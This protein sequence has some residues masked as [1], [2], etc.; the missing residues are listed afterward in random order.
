MEDHRGVGTG[1][2]EGADPIDQIYQSLVDKINI[3]DK[4]NAEYKVKQE[5]HFI[6]A[7]MN[8]I[9]KIGNEL[10][11]AQ[12]AYKNVDWEVRKDSY[13]FELAE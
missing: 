4:L 2:A 7:F 13:C 3:L 5:H 8:V 6:N 11:L 12:E 1:G 9:E 10:L